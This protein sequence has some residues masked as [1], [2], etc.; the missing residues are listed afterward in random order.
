MLLSSK[1]LWCG[2][3]CLGPICSCFNYTVFCCYVMVTISMQ[4][5]T[6]VSGI[7]INTYGWGSILFWI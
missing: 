3:N 5:R 1:Q 4:V 2:T 6:G 7:P